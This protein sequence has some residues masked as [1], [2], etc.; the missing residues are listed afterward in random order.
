M[1]CEQCWCGSRERAGVGE[2]R[3][4]LLLLL[5]L[6]LL[7]SWSMPW[8][9]RRSRTGA[10]YAGRLASKSRA[11]SKGNWVKSE[12]K[13]PRAGRTSVGWTSRAAE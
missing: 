6:F 13:N 5:L 1:R 9:T 11:L 10:T 7:L 2:G 8:A 3:L 4:P 12:G